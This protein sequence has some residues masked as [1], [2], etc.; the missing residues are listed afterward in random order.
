MEQSAQRYQIYLEQMQ[1]LEQFREEYQTVYSTAALERD[2]P[3]LAR[4][5]EAIAYFSAYTQEV[6]QQQIKQLHKHLVEQI[7]PYV[8]SPLPAKTILQLVPEKLNEIVH[9]TKGSTFQLEAE[10]GKTALFKSC[11]LVRLLPIQLCSIDTEDVF[12]D[13][14]NLKL[15]F[16]AFVEMNQAPGELPIYLNVLNDFSQ[17]LNWYNAIMLSAHS[18]TVSFDNDKHRQTESCE[19]TF[20]EP[21]MPL[22][23]HP[24][25]QYRNL[26]HFP[27]LQ[28]FLH[29]NIT[30]SPESWRSFSLHLNIEKPFVGGKLFKSFF[31]LFCT[32]LINLREESGKDIWADGKVSKYYIYPPELEEDLELHS[33]KGLF[34]RGGNQKQ[35]LIPSVIQG[36]QNTYAFTNS[37][38]EGPSIDLNIPDAFETPRAISVEG[39]WHQPDFSASL[40]QKI[41]VSPFEID[42]PGV[43]WLINKE[44]TGCLPSLF[45]PGRLSLLEMLSIHSGYEISSTYLTHLFYLF[46]SQWAKEFRFICSG[47]TGF[48]DTGTHNKYDFGLR[49][50][51]EDNE[52]VLLFITYFQQIVNVWF[53]VSDFK[54]NLVRQP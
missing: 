37:E 41:K 15:N 29:F 45:E 26:L 42:I 43:E 23:M 46:S 49:F 48:Y 25:E 36:G 27:Y 10:E 3:E 2:D 8:C 16:E 12:P 13:R 18:V 6:G 33:L 20:S 40:W 4:L 53:D 21:D 17:T 52:P 1:A 44:R 9:I 11:A 50:L 28:F 54:L 38:P 51:E 47:F 5:T 32:P 35:P 22:G 7:H 24:I 39:Y 19:L 30:K 31:R 34:Q 14:I